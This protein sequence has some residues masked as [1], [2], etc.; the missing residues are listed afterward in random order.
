MQ[1]KVLYVGLDV[2]KKI[3][4]YCVMN[5]QGEI[6]REGKIAASRKAL[7]DWVES[8]EQPWMGALVATVFTGWFYDFLT[9]Y[10]EELKVAHPLIIR[11]ICASKKKNDKV[12]AQKLA[13]AL[14]ANLLPECYMAPSEIRELRRVL[15]F[16]SLVVEMVVKMKNKCS[17]LLMEVGAEYDKAALHRKHYF[18]ELLGSLELPESLKQMLSLSRAHI[19]MLQACQK[20]LVKGLRKNPLIAER[21]KRLQSIRGVGEILALTWVLEVGECSRFPSIG[22]AWSY[23]GLTS[24]QDES[25][26]KTKRLPISKQRNRHLQTILIEAA[27]LAPRF[28][29]QLKAVHERELARGNRN[30]ATLAVARKLVAYLLAVDRS[31]K[32]FEERPSA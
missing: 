22:C 14:R 6:V 32:C 17:G 27:K 8:L 25:A 29:P 24:A 23:C 5:V 13:N 16:R 31:G 3:I 2:H 15:R 1:K 26:G 30:R 21:V 10:A 11:A 18:H 19:D 7:L 9:P 4:A 20:K 28:N 12:D